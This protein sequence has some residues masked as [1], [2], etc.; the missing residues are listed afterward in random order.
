MCAGDFNL[1]RDWSP[2]AN[3]TVDTADLLTVSGWDIMKGVAQRYQQVFPTL[4]PT[5]YS[6]ANYSF[7]HTD[8][9][10]SQ[11]S[12]RAFADGLFGQFETVQFETVPTDD[13]FLRV[14][15]FETFTVT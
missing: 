1:V 14:K 6:R 3:I 12:I 10:R 4:L 15:R 7:R 8:R 5:T 9:Q 2:D 11:G 13:T